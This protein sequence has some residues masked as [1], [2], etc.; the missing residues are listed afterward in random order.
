MSQKI[1]YIHIG[2]SKTGTSAIQSQLDL[3][4]NK[5]KSKSI[6]YSKRM[7]MNDQAHH[8]FALAFSPIHGYP[9]Q[10][11]IDQVITALNE[12]MSEN[13]CESLLLSSELSPF[14]F[15]N[16]KFC[17]WVERFDSIK[18]IATVRRQSE[19]LLSLF[20]QLVK[21]PQVRYKGTFFQMAITNFPKMNFYQHLQ[22]WASKVGDDNIVVMNYD[23]GVVKQFLEYFNLEVDLENILTIVNPSLPN[24]TLRL[25]QEKTKGV[26]E[27][28]KYRKIRDLLISEYNTCLN[29]PEKLFLTKGE[30]DAI[31]NHFLYP[32]NI[33]AKRFIGKEMLFSAKKNEGLY[34]Y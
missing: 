31:D 24:N 25:M 1:L 11:N 20:N 29:E 13:D 22:N 18:I 19:L 5:L 12:E 2:W 6:L 32:N 16:P 21:D 7:Q 34:V 17:K 15:N 33:L 30:L 26:N 3:Q 27:P 4:F 10:Y 28:N 8:H 14:Y 9:A 23:D